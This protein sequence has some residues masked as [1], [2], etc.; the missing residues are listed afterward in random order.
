MPFKFF[1]VSRN[2]SDDFVRVILKKRIWERLHL[3]S[4]LEPTPIFAMELLSEIDKGKEP[5]TI[6]V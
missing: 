5:S 3:E 1:L 4:D 2:P 6:F